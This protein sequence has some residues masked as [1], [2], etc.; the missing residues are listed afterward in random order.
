[1]ILPFN[2]LV[3]PAAADEPLPRLR[4]FEIEVRAFFVIPDFVVVR[5]EDGGEWF[6]RREEEGGEA[7]GDAQRGR[8]TLEKL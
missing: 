7:S 1:L 6:R 3:A 5:W 2:N 4:A 8:C